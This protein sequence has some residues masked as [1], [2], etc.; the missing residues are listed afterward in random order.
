[1]SG[2][3]FLSAG[4]RAQMALSQQTADGA[5]TNVGLAWRIAA[6]PAGRT[7]LHH[8]G[9]VTGGRAFALFYPA[10]RVSVVIVT[11]LGFASFDQKDALALA[12]PFLA[13]RR[14]G[15]AAEDR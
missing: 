1:M 7:Y 9:A 10:E 5:K 15:A 6:D 11:N 2:E 14:G 13:A 8:G 3:R 4:S 12:A